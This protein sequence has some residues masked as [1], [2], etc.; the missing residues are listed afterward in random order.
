VKKENQNKEIFQF[1]MK[2]R[3][4]YLVER[5]RPWLQTNGGPFQILRASTSGKTVAIP[6]VLSVP[7]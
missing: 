4:H 1:K 7:L 2:S 6:E 5:L 3:S